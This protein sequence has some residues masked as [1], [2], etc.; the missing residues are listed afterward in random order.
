MAI[1]K[2]VNRMVGWLELHL[3]GSWVLR[4]CESLASLI[5]HPCNPVL[6][7]SWFTIGTV[8]DLSGST[9][10]LLKQPM[11]CRRPLYARVLQVEILCHFLTPRYVIESFSFTRSSTI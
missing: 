2:V 9:P 4:S 6:V 5:G 1:F 11:W 10:T 8:D 7:M 3:R